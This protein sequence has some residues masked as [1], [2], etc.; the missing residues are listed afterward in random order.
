MINTRKF[1]DDEQQVLEINRKTRKFIS[2]AFLF[3]CFCFVCS[4]FAFVFAHV[5]LLFCFVLKKKVVLFINQKSNC[6]TVFS[7][8]LK[9]F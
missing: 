9:R 8:D 5:S 7:P 4:C 2:C 1:P 6:T 3:I